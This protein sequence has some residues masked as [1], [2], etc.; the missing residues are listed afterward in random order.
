MQTKVNNYYNNDKNKI[1][2]LIAKN[3]LKSLEIAK[4]YL[5]RLT[6][7]K[8]VMFHYKK[9]DPVTLTHKLFYT[10][11]NLTMSELFTGRSDFEL[12]E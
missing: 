9:I 2:S 10:G 4:N 11:S 7:E 6:Q 1:E 5:S 12:M 8:I 3:H